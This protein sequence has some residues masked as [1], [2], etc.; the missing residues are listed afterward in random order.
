MLT[1]QQ[2]K[3]GYTFF[4]KGEPVAATDRKEMLTQETNTDGNCIS[5]MFAIRVK[6]LLQK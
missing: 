3:T 4:E 1:T 6:P 5:L 2:L